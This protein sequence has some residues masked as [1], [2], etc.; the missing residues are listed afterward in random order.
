L[1]K[2]TKTNKL[3]QN[4]TNYNKNIFIKLD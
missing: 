4:Y 2:K 3:F 1:K